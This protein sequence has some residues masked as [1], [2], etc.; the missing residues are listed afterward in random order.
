MINSEA[1]LPIQS[2]KQQ[3]NPNRGA[4]FEPLSSR[5]PFCGCQEIFTTVFPEDSI[6][7]RTFQK[8]KMQQVKK[9]KNL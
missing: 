4:S 3:P 7:Q 2:S 5:L 9:S 8:W 6:L 1:F